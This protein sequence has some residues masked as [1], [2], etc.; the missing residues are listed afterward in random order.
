M[1]QPVGNNFYVDVRSEQLRGVGM[2]ETM[3][4]PFLR[5]ARFKGDWAAVDDPR[6]AGIKKENRQAGAGGEIVP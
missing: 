2:T 1:P 3:Q 5:H 6:A 4:V